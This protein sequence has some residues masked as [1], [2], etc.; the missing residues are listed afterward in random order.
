MTDVLSKIEQEY[1]NFSKGQKKIAKYI[2]EHYEKAAYM[3]A[4]KLGETVGISES[5][6]VRFATEL[7]YDGYPKFQKDLTNFIRTK[8]TAVQRIQVSNDR[9]EK[10]GILESVLTSDI[11][12]IKT[13]LAEIDHDEFEK[14]I[15]ELVSAEKIYILGVRSS[16]ALAN[17]MGFYFNLMFDN[18][19][20]VN[21]ASSSEIFEQVVRVTEKDVVIGISFPR[22]SQRTVKMLGYATSKGAKTIAL[23]DS[24][25]SPVSQNAKYTLIAKSDMASFADSVV[26]PL[27]VI[28]SI[29]AAIGQR[30][31]DDISKML[32]S[33][34][35]MWDENEVYNLGEIWE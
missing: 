6:V 15:T 19:K 14:V 33:L 11:E 29:I 10:T 4:S 7:G 23:T 30:K 13:T 5:T 3:T 32:E 31:P 1:N 18:V 27:S 35:K 22:Y 12:Q 8:L 28:N 20:I 2:L 9:M 17:F 26:A 34:E 25:D 24:K 21:S 16:A